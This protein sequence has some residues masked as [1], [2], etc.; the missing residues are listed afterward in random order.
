MSNWRG[1]KCMLQS[2]ITHTDSYTL[3]CG[4]ASEEVFEKRGVSRVYSLMMCQQLSRRSNWAYDTVKEKRYDVF[5]IHYAKK[6]SFNLTLTHRD[7]NRDANGGQLEVLHSRT[8]EDTALLLLSVYCQKIISKWQVHFY[9]S[10]DDIETLTVTAYV[11]A[12]PLSREFLVILKALFE[13]EGNCKSLL[14]YLK[15]PLW[16]ARAG[17]IDIIT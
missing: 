11:W 8:V 15:S 16:G 17:R 6:R 2:L 7:Q 13:T 9:D 1:S 3:R 12:K 14:C 4:E 10:A 5:L